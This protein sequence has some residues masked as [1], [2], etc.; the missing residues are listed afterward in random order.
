MVHEVDLKYGNERL[1]VCV[2]VHILSL[3]RTTNPERPE[4]TGDAANDSGGL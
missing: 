4:R 3:G 2:C 1:C